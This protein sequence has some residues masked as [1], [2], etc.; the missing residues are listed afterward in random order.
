MLKRLGLDGSSDSSY[1]DDAQ[2]DNGAGDEDALLKARGAFFEQILSDRGDIKLYDWQDR[3]S[4][5]YGYGGAEFPV[6]SLYPHVIYMGALD[7][8]GDERLMYLAAH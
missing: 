8:S 5:A 1:S 4:G 6:G 3:N 7:E 2:Q